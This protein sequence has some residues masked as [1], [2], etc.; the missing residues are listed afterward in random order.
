MNSSKSKKFKLKINF[1]DYL[2]HGYWHHSNEPPISTARKILTNLEHD[3]G[4]GYWIWGK[5][6]KNGKVNVEYHA[7]S[8]VFKK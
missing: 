3:L 7:E 8:Q 2:I 5:T 4:P 6:Q 1:A